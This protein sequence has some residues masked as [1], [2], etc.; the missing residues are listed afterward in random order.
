M[1]VDT[2]CVYHLEEPGQISTP[3]FP[4][5]YGLEKY[6]LWTITAP[7][8]EYVL[9]DISSF[10]VGGPTYLQLVCHESILSN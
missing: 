5:Y 8:D 3:N 4:Y 7:R 9:V 1:F 6:C 2:K 10:R